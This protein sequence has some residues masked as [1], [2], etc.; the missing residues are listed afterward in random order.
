HPGTYM[1]TNMV[2]GAGVEPVTPLE[3]GV[4][5]TMRLITS[6]ELD[7]VNGHYFDGTSESAPQ[8][9]AEDP[10][11]RRR[12]RELSEELTGIHSAA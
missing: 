3:D 6:P 1:P 9:Q 4:A 12:L 11:A 2:R 5:A 8:P 10:E 7:G